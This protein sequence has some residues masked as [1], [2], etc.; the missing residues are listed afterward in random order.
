MSTVALVGRPNVGKSTLFNRLARKPLAIV[1]DMPGLTRD[2][3]YAEIMLGDR[4]VT[5]VDTGGMEPKPKGSI[6]E[7]VQE[8]TK[9][10]IEEAAVVVFIVDARAGLTAE[11]QA[12]AR[13]LRKTGKPVIVCANK[14]EGPREEATSS[15]FH[16]LG[17]D[18]VVL[19]SAEHGRNVKALVDLVLGFL[20]VAKEVAPVK[21]ALCSIAVLGRPNV[22]KS[23]LVNRL[24]GEERMIASAEPGTTRDAIDAVVE[25]E[26]ERYV[27]IDTAGLRRKARIEEQLE[28]Q[29]VGSALRSLKRAD[30][31][32][33][34][35]DATELATE[36][37]A[38]LARV[39]LDHGKSLI[40]IINKWDLR[41]KKLN[42]QNFKEEMQRRFPHLMG[43]RYVYASALT[44]QGLEVLFPEINAT[45]AEWRR[46]VSTGEL[47]RFIDAAQERHPTPMYNGKRGKIYYLSQVGIEPPTMAM[48]V[49]DPERFPDAY[50]RYL[51][52]QLRDEFGFEGTP[53]VFYLRKRHGRGEKAVV[54]KGERKKDGRKKTG[55]EKTGR[56]KGGREK[57]AS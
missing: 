20:P 47:N 16:R 37:E 54:E 40:F 49:N 12:I 39:V 8:Q 52:A 38:K 32:L 2:R 35:L 33:L 4:P 42:P 53:V 17:F 31:A 51:E 44:G 21:D 46:R 11:D 30:V 43:A 22:G 48:M 3:H 34:V 24:L 50:K 56:E 7:R 15:E 9:L 13:Q 41:D 14:V 25:H 36:Q 5:L 26:G 27:F 57:G 19:I 10:G 1:Q 28:E 55:R 18:E 23:S 6:N 29:M 45:L